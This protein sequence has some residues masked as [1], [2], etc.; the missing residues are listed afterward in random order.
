VVRAWLY[1]RADAVRLSALA[2]SPLGSFAALARTLQREE[3]YHLLFSDAWVVRLARSGPEGRTHIQT[4]LV[5]AWPDALGFFEASPP[6]ATLVE[7]GA[8]R[9]SV[10]EQQAQWEAAVRGRLADLELSAPAGEARTGGRTGQHT[11]ELAGLL[12]EMT[13]VWRTDPS[14]RW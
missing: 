3:K 11:P 8:L 6:L 9:P 13:S 2:A 14:A 1:D 10:A 7:A 4:A 5:A 12:D